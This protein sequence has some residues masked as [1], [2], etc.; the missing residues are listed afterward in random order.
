MEKKLYNKNTEDTPY[1]EIFHSQ[2]KLSAIVYACILDLLYVMSIE[3]FQYNTNN[4]FLFFYDLKNLL[5]NL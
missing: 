1:N 2:K 3:K 4:L 5:N